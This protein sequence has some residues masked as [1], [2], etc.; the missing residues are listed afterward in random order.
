MLNQ[1]SI[2]D[3]LP[4]WL[5]KGTAWLDGMTAQRQMNPNAADLLA[6]A[7]NEDLQQ[8][9]QDGQLLQLTASEQDI[10]NASY[11]VEWEDYLVV[12]VLVDTYGRSKF[13]VF[14]TNAHSGVE[15]SFE[16]AFAISMSSYVNK[17]GGKISIMDS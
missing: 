15:Q 11:N 3:S 9:E 14:L 13:N 7:Y 8:A 6:R 17:I 16:N 12:K 2:G 5:N 1:E 4:T 10:L